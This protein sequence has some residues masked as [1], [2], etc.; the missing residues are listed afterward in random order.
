MANDLLNRDED[1]F[2]NSIM[3]K[4]KSKIIP[5]ITADFEKIITERME[6]SVKHFDTLQES[7][8]E[9]ENKVTNMV[10]KTKRTA[11]VLDKMVLKQPELNDFISQNTTNLKLLKDYIYYTKADINL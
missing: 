11:N 8:P 6:N 1:S 9:I 10:T 4:L 2:Q 3:Q 5:K 7:I